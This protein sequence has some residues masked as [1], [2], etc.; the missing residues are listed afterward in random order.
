MTLYAAAAPSGSWDIR[1]SKP[2]ELICIALCV[3]NAVYLLVSFVAGQVF[4]DASGHG[5]PTD[6]VNVWAAGRLVLEGQ[7]QAAYDWSI[8]KMVEDAAIGRAFEGYFAWLYPPTFLFAA[9]LLAT[10]PLVTAQVV[11][12]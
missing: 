3:T 11:W 9:A 5:I 1:T 6:F 10:L 7:P 2:F 4:I 8:H 12:C